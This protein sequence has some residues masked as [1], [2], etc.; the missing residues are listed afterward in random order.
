MFAN[1]LKI[2]IHFFFGGGF[3]L[4]QKASSVWE[5]SFRISV[6]RSH[7]NQFFFFK[8]EQI[9]MKDLESAES[10][11]KSNF[12]LFRFLIFELW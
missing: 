12:R 8:I 11:E 1:F 9:Y 10:N 6:L 7:Q 5:F 2:K 4:H 3:D